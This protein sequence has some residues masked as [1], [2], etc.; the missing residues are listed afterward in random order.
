M[1]MWSVWQPDRNVFFN[2]YFIRRPDGNIVVDPLAWTSEDE[3]QMEALGGVAHIITTNRDHERMSQLLAETFGAKVAAGE[4]DA[5][6]LKQQ[7]VASLREGDEPF[8]GARVIAFDGLKSPGEIAL[9]LPG[10]KAAIVGDALWGDP[11]GTVRLLADDKLLDPKAAVLSLR[12]LWALRLEHLLVGDGA[13]IFGGADRVI[14]DYLQSRADVYVNRINVDEINA[15]SYPHMSEAHRAAASAGNYEAFLQEIGD[16]IGARR[17]GYW[18]AT[19]P[20]GKKFCPLHS[21]QLEEELFFVLEGEPTIRTPRGDF[22]CRKG[23]MICFPVGDVGTHQLVNRSDKPCTVF[24]LGNDEREE[25]AYYPDSKKVL[26][27]GRK[28]RVRSEPALDY[29]D[30]ET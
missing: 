23:D 22:A 13:C 12:K 3:K 18:I 25:V 17:L 11:A 27:R 20:P 10:S 15:I 21:H 16:F 26:V 14:G 7:V 28:L 29:Y 30:G 5:P 1:Y 19:V 4:R 2:S 6:L 24:L 8:S 9:S